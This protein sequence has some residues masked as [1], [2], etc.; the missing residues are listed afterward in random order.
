MSVALDIAAAAPQS[1][2]V[3]LRFAEA[4]ARLA[5]FEARPHLAIAVSGGSDSMA[6][7]LLAADWARSRGGKATAVTVDHGLRAEAAGEAAQVAAWCAAR[8]IDHAILR[9]TGPPLRSGI[10]AAA[11]AARYALL[12]AWCREQR[13]LHLLLAHQR[14]DQ[15]ETVKMR[16]T[17]NSGMRGLAGMASVSERGA[18]RLLRPLLAVSRAQLRVFLGAR[19]QSWLDDPSNDNPAFT[20]VRVRAALGKTQSGSSDAHLGGTAAGLAGQRAEFEAADAQR[21]ACWLTLD[22]AG[23]AWLDPAAFADTGGLDA[24]ALGAVLAMISGSDFPPRGER[25]DRLHQALASGL[26]QDRT[27]GGCLVLKRRNKFLICREP[28]MAAAPVALPVGAETAWD[29]RFRVALPAGAPEGLSLGALGEEGAKLV[30]KL[31]KSAVLMIPT[32]ARA[33]LPALCDAKGVV[34]VPALGYFKCCSQEAMTAARH[35]HFRPIRPLTGAG[36]TIV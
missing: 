26:A 33:T 5:P 24:V 21:L 10:Q 17:R 4:M 18:V 31:P 14:D 3:T 27:L 36:F 8:A 16:H 6:L 29:G 13:V 9:R 35:L 15:A 2:F 1:D 22:P 11:R 12:E 28:A 25:L 20:R 7:A 30:R 23:F 32:A 34:A 19:G